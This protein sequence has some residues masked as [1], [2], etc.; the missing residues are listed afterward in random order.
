MEQAELRGAF[1]SYALNAAYH[2]GQRRIIPFLAMPEIGALI[3]GAANSAAALDMLISHFRPPAIPA[4]NYNLLLEQMEAARPDIAKGAR[5]DGTETKT[6]AEAA[7]ERLLK[8]PFPLDLPNEASPETESH[9]QEQAAPLAEPTEAESPESTETEPPPAIPGKGRNM[10]NK[11][12][13]ESKTPFADFFFSGLK[14]LSETGQELTEKGKTILDVKTALKAL[15]LESQK[16]I[17][18]ILFW[19]DP[20]AGILDFQTLWIKKI[21]L[22]YFL[23]TKQYRGQKAAMLAEMQELNKQEAAGLQLM[24]SQPTPPIIEGGAAELSRILKV[25]EPHPFFTTPH[26]EHIKYCAKINKAFKAIKAMPEK[27]RK[28]ARIKAIKQ[29]L[30]DYAFLTFYLFEVEYCEQTQKET[31]GKSRGQIAA[32]IVLNRRFFNADVFADFDYCINQI[33][34][35]DIERQSIDYLKSRRRFLEKEV[36]A[37]E[38]YTLCRAA[39]MDIVATYKKIG[40]LMSKEQ[41]KAAAQSEFIQ[42]RIKRDFFKHFYS[43]TNS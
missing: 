3:E 22:N 16:D 18:K 5:K 33:S 28:A 35:A 27:K 13:N 15:Q 43:I 17:K 39:L 4:K 14:Q 9:A 34:A 20:K 23:H 10:A 1:I 12:K 37:Q 7:A 11:D 40:L 41:M 32:E 30:K 29:I 2:A 6:A 31:K 19:T 8:R 42:D 21:L 26:G 36:F 38:D 25:N 24:K